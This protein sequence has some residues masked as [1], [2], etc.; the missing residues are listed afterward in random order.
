[1][2][3]TCSARHFGQHLMELYGG[4]LLIIISL[5]TLSKVEGLSVMQLAAKHSAILGR[6]HPTCPSKQTML[7]INE[8]PGLLGVR[9]FRISF[10][11]ALST[12][13]QHSPRR[14]G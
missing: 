7:S 6:S 3:D 12:L 4:R 5:S 11:V 1:M 13:P 8:P 14:K 9:G 2:L 10:P